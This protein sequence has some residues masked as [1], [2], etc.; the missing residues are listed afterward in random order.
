MRRSAGV[1]GQQVLPGARVAQRDARIAA[2][3]RGGARRARA[4]GR[5]SRHEHHARRRARGCRSATSAAIGPPSE[6]PTSTGRARPD[7]PRTPRAGARPRASRCERRRG[8][9]RAAEPRHVGD[10]HA[11]ARARAAGPS[12]ASSGTCRRARGSARSAGR[13]PTR[14]GARVRRPPDAAGPQRH[15]RQRIVSVALGHAATGPR[16]RAR[17]AAPASELCEPVARLG[18]G[19]L[20]HPVDDRVHVRHRHALVDHPGTERAEDPA[21]VVLGPQAAERSGAR[22]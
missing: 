12:R 13:L 7:A 8:R 6:W 10:Q 3:A 17:P 21:Q 9:M 18:V 19:D 16:R 11:V 22:S 1:R 20:A 14:R 2:A 5:S 15:A 4:R